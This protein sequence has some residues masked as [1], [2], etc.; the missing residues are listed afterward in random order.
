M[1]VSYTV[2]E[3]SFKTDKPRLWSGQ[4]VV[5]LARGRSFN[6]HPDGERIAVALAAGQTE[7]KLDQ[8][9]FIFNVFDECAESELLEGVTLGERAEEWRAA[10]THGNRLRRAGRPWTRCR[11]RQ[12]DLPPRS[13]AGQYFHHHRWPGQNSRLRS[14]EAQ[15][16]SI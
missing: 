8:L 14:C 9:T 2:E 13:K 6:L 4:Q 1:V 5:S 3:D 15:R 7:E 16:G 11:P 12:R 10:D